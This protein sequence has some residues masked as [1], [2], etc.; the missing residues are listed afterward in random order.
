MATIAQLDEFIQELQ[1]HDWYYEYSDDGSV[2]R[3]G[4]AQRQALEAKADRD[5]DL[6]IALSTY[7][8]CYFNDTRAWEDK[9]EFRDRLIDA[10]RTDLQIA[11]MTEL[12]APSNEVV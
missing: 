10:L 5:L 1:C 3:R 11:A 4:R 12:I 9:K 6:A 8:N 2:W 7:K